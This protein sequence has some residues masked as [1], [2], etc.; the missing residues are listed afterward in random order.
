MIEKAQDNQILLPSP[1]TV[2][3][4]VSV[5]RWFLFYSLFL[6]AAG[7]PLISML[8]GEHSWRNWW[9]HCGQ[10]FSHITWATL[11]SGIKQE[12]YAL[13]RVFAKSDVNIKLLF[14]LI[15]V[16]LATT[17]MPLPTGMLIAG[18]AMRDTA[19]ANDVWSVTLLIAL[20]GGVASTIA[21]LNDYHFFT[22]LLRSRHVAKVRHTKLYDV[23]ARWFA[24]SPFYIL[25]LFN[26]IPLPIDVIRLLA[27][28]YRYSRVKFA[29]ANFIGR[30]VRYAVIAFLTYYFD[31]GWVAP[32]A[33][34]GLAVVLAMIKVAPAAWKRIIGKRK[35]REFVNS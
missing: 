8:A 23:S 35:E 11:L 19:V 30:F 24:R 1:N 28:T 20:V 17:Y 3:D 13:G 18:M 26:I 7:I 5:L 14:A 27:I 4:A 16:S 31:L 2:P 12:A 34:L 6:L 22:W 21:N 10:T 32:L 9:D 33:L 15:Y 25:L 29:V